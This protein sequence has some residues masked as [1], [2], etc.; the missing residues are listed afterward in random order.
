ML[1][2]LCGSPAAAALRCLAPYGRLVNL[3][4]SA[5]PTMALDSATLR[6]RSLRVLG[7]TNNELTAAQRVMALD[8]VLE[9][10]AAGT[11]SLDYDTAVIDDVTATWRKQASGNADRRIV[12][13]FDDVLP[14]AQ[15]H[16][17]GVSS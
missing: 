4:S 9:H 2:P 6:S 10:A 5:A 15:A 14:A 7:Y 8:A 13:T 12:L 1:D 16:S 17:Q 3:D 11:L